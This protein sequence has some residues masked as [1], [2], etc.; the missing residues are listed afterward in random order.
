MSASSARY[1]RNRPPKDNHW[2]RRETA[3]LQPSRKS[4]KPLGLDALRELLRQVA[5]AGRQH[6]ASPHVSSGLIPLDSMLPGG[7]V[8]KAAL[9]EILFTEDGSG[10]IGLAVCFARHAAGNCGKVILVEG[11]DSHARLYPP[12]LVQTG[13]K[14]H[15]I[16][17]V[18]AASRRDA[19]WACEQ[20]LRCTGVS[21]VVACHEGL[22]YLDTRTSRVFQL[23]SEEGGGLGLLVRRA[24]LPG[25]RHWDR[26]TCRPPA[27][28]GGPDQSPSAPCGALRH[29]ADLPSGRGAFLAATSRERSFAAVRLLVEPWPR[30]KPSPAAPLPRGSPL[31][32]MRIWIL[33]TRET[34]LAEPIRVDVFD[35]AGDVSTPPVPGDRARGS[36][37]C[38]ATA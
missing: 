28:T 38:L 15:Q 10:A 14:G 24:D 2:I 34:T 3:A 23:A 8:P 36:P 25:L 20:S 22:R 6:F 30:D 31:T 19:I 4:F 37:E 7:G 5:R 9:T 17:L 26:T 13:L 12:A 21:A 27:K 35:E 11:R 33:R 29:P 1:A 18:R 16:V 32:A